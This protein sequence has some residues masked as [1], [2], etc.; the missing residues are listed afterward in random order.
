[1]VDTF[2]RLTLMFQH[3]FSSLQ[4]QVGP[5]HKII[6]MFLV[7]MNEVPFYYII[8]KTHTIENSTLPCCSS[9]CHWQNA[10]GL[11]NFM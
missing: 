10:G 9:L 11:Y 5:I 7:A 3:P 8:R 4:N 1:M 2:F 6:C